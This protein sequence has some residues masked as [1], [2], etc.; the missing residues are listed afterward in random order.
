MIGNKTSQLIV[1]FITVSLLFMLS[2][3]SRSF[4]GIYIFDYRIGEYLVLFAFLFSLII[5]IKY[6]YFKALISNKLYIFHILL[7]INFFAS[8][9]YYQANF[10]DTYI[11]KSSSYIWAIGFIYI[12]FIIKNFFNIESKYFSLIMVLLPIIYILQ[13]GYFFELSVIYPFD[14][15]QGYSDDNLLNFFINYS[16]K[17][18]TYKGT[19]LLLFFVI[20]TFILNRSNLYNRSKYTLMYFACISAL[21]LPLFLKISRAAAICAV[22]Y[23]AIEGYTTYKVDKVKLQ[24]L[25][26]I[27]ATSFV[28]LNL[29][30]ANLTDK[31]FIDFD[32][33]SNFDDLSEGQEITQ[34]AFLK[35]VDGRVYS[36]DGNLNWRL[37]I[38]QDVINYS[39]NNS[40]IFFGSGYQEIIPAMQIEGRAGSDGLNENVHNFLINIYARG[41]LLQLGIFSCILVIIFINSNPKRYTGN[42]YAAVSSLLLASLFDA[43]MENVHFPLILYLFIGFIIALNKDYN[44]N[45]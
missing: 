35:I 3:F 31:D 15:V 19:D 8:L 10:R 9:V 41:G 30:I 21:F 16:D 36:S 12:G 27:A 1:K 42:F 29:S 37:Q 14:V 43:S 45:K 24:K 38:W 18:E 20:L 7:I 28:I 44:Y 25:I 5:I 32:I 17:F 26:L 13:T 6:Q 33:A 23:V 40:T 22:L 11:F 39:V 2:I 4:V 34:E